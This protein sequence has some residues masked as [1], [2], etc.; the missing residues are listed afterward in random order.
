M[1][2]Y[3]ILH[4]KMSFH[5]GEVGPE[6][7]GKDLIR[8]V[9]FTDPVKIGVITDVQGMDVYAMITDEDTINEL[10]NDNPASLGMEIVDKE[11]K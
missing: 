1:S 2:K 6:L 9:N 5:K 7:I 8:Y 3:D 4:V 11:V 10:L